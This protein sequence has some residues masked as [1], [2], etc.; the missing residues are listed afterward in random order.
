M[1]TST[2]EQFGLLP[3]PSP[4]NKDQTCYILPPSAQ[5]LAPDLWVCASTPPGDC[6]CSFAFLEEQGRTDEAVFCT[7]LLYGEG[8]LGNLRE[9]RH[10]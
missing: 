10:T 6:W 8:P 9:C 7:I 1:S 3:T 4:W 2:L 5:E